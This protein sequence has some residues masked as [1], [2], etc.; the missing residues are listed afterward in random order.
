MNEICKIY[1]NEDD[2]L[3]FTKKKS[4]KHTQCQI[5]FYYNFISADF[6]LFPSLIISLQSDYLIH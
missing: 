1:L 4:A 3:L 6:V 2:V 5:N